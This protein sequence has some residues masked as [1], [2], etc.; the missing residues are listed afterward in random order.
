MHELSL[1]CFE[2]VMD[3]AHISVPVFVYVGLKDEVLG[4]VNP[5]GWLPT[6]IQ[7]C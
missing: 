3:S 1:Y 2:N 7:K 6:Q 4:T 5:S